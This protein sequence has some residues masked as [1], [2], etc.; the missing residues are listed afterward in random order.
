[1]ISPKPSRPLIHRNLVPMPPPP[2]AAPRFYLLP[3]ALKPF[4]FS[5]RVPMIA[6]FVIDGPLCVSPAISSE[7][8]AAVSSSQETLRGHRRRSQK[9]RPYRPGPHGSSHGHEF[10]EGWF[11]SYRLESHRFESR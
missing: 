6:E 11:R 7:F 4:N 5:R 1:M 8:I 10:V 2:S 9:N 3:V